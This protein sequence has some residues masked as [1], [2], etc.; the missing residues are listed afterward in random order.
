MKLLKHSTAVKVIS[1]HSFALMISYASLKS[2]P[3]ANTN[4]HTDLL[5][6]PPSNSVNPLAPTRHAH[7]T[8]MHTHIQY[9]NTHMQPHAHK[10]THFKP[11]ETCSSNKDS[12]SAHIYLTLI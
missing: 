5:T 7:T 8:H 6:H 2:Y 4:K 12:K 9:E 1:E 3:S 10:H 11:P